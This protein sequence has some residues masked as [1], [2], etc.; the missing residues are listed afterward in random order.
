MARI[1]Q[2]GSELTEVPFGEFLS[3][4]A[5]GIADGQRALDLTSVQTLIELSNTMVQFIPEVTEV[6]TPEPFQVEVSGHDPIEVT[7]ARVTSTPSPPVSMSALQAGIV[8]TFYQ[9]SNATILLKMSVQLRQVEETDTDGS[10]Q[11]AIRPFSSHVNFRTQNTFTYNVE[12]SSSVTAVMVPVPAPTRLVPATVM[13][14]ALGQG[15]PTVTV[16][17]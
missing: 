15:T 6:V 12:A 3:N 7:G 5:Q 10:T 4:I 17:T 1:T 14:N 2:V 9:F 16:S 8:P 11:Q 13:V